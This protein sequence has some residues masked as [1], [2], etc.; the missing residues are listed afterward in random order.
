MAHGHPGG[1]PGGGGG[2]NYA[3]TP[4]I[5]TW[6]VT[7]ACDLECDHCR[8]DAQP[9]RD[10]NEL[11][12]AEGKA[13]I[14]Q[15]ADFGHPPPVFV[16]SGGDPLKRPDLYEL[17]E[18]ATDQGLPTAVTP[19]PTS[20]LDRDVLE[21][22]ADLGV[23]R[24]ALSLDGATPESHD[25]FR[26]EEGSFELIMDRAEMAK[27]AG[28]GIQIN[29]TVTANTADELPEIADLVEE[30]G[31]AMWEVF[32]LVPIGRGTELDQLEPEAT[33]DVMEFLYE[34]QKSAPFR[35]I[36]VEAP[37]YRVVAKEV[38]Q[39]AT[40]NDVR[41][42]STRAGKGF[43]FVSHEGDVFPSGFLP[44]TGGNVTETSLVDIY[45]D[46]DLFE[47]LRDD[48]QLT[49][50]CRTCEHREL[51]GGSRSRAYAVTGNPMASDPLCPYVEELIS[52]DPPEA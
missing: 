34:R 2:R 19:A 30:L 15:I 32:F 47:M 8:A 49:G 28:L 3:Q 13:L 42:G 20:L 26:G 39:A 17:I 27:E 9:D 14:D 37:H 21:T 38:E 40:G 52:E 6:E 25:T 33:R 31:A 44:L 7:Q 51:C 16:I 18:H 36:T 43:V 11:S 12:T 46:A 50:T 5:A 35:T 1:H 41:V 10:P 24:I 4:L 22:F 29:T 48:S 23:K 45:R